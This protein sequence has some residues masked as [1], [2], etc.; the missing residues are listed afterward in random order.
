M[1]SADLEL[2]EGVLAKSHERVLGKLKRNERRLTALVAALVATQ[3]IPG[4]DVRAI[5]QRRV[6]R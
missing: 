5:L 1:T 2:A 6:T 4:N 3:E